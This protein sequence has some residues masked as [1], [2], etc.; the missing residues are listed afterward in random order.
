MWVIKRDSQGAEVTRYP[1]EEI[2]HQDATSICLRAVFTRADTAVGSIHLREGDRLTEWF[3][4]D[5]WYNVFLIRNEHT[6]EEKG[7]YCNFTRPAEMGDDFVVA[8]DL[9]LDLAITP[10]KQIQILDLKEYLSLSIT[11]TERWAV[12]AAFREITQ[13]LHT[14]QFPF[15]DP[16]SHPIES[17][18]R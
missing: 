14:S 3:F 13:L 18:Q 5:R 17:S 6:M 8:D 12:A 10:T 11:V 9:S 4:T 7:W 1:A 2:L 15:G 16:S